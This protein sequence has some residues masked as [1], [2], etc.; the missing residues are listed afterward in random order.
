MVISSRPVELGSSDDLG[1]WV[2]VPLARLLLRWAH[3]LSCAL[4]VATAIWVAHGVF[5]PMDRTDAGIDYIAVSPSSTRFALDLVLTLAALLGWQAFVLWRWR[6]SFSLRAWLRLDHAHHLSPLLLLGLSLVPAVNL[7]SPHGPW[8]APWSYLLV[9]LRG[10]WW[11]LVLV[12]VVHA[13]RPEG[14]GPLWRR[15]RLLPDHWAE[16]SI[17]AVAVGA[18]CMS[19]PNVLRFSSNVGGDEPRYLRYC[20]NLYQGLGFDLAALKRLDELPADFEPRVFDNIRSL[21]T[22]VSAESWNLVTDG[23]ALLAGRRQFNRARYLGRWFLEGKQPGTV[24][25]VHT[26]GLGMILFPAYYLDRRAL[27]S[28]WTLDGKFPDP[29]HMLNIGLLTLFALYALVVFRLLRSQADDIRL[30]WV[31]ALLAMVTIPVGAFAFQVYPK[32][33]QAPWSSRR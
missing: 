25:Q 26:P 8:W 28:G 12:W 18:A 24:Y 1:P 29:M 27:S 6:Q 21:G 5:L 13:S 9:D 22:T 23:R 20:E 15:L 19:S 3:F 31:L 33:R 16:V 2:A 32:S 30:A 7:A 11:A 17:V 4:V 10:W 14:L